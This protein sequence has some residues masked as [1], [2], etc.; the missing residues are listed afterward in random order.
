M[1][2]R[3]VSTTVVALALLVPLGCGNDGGSEGTAAAGGGV[4]VVTSFY[5]LQY[6][7][8]R[9][10]GDRV[11]V[12]NLTPPGAEPHDLE[13]TPQDLARLTDAD[14]VVYLAGFSPAV[15]DAVAA[16][17]GDRA[18]EVGQFADLNLTLTP[19]EEGAF[20][21]GD[22]GVDPHFW[23]DPTRLAD[24]ADQVAQRLGQDDPDGAQGF[25][26][27]AAA[28][29]RD[30]EAL[31]GELAAGLKDCENR[32]I[33]TSHNA[34]GYLADRFGMTQVGITGLTPDEEPTP[35]DL[36]AVTRFVKDH[37]VKTIYYETL[38]SP[39][40]AKT[41]AAETGA[42]SAVLDPIEGLSDASDGSD[43]L[44]VMR[45]NLASLQA[46]QPCG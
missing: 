46:G 22:K 39:A 6:V 5:P 10:G 15:D 3:S 13:L 37:D 31:D 11:A 32:S 19:S 2:P 29:R 14:L 43:Y 23:L 12:T 36:A 38:V 7:V 33:V 20:A 44:S 8:D 25:S 4:A 42:A 16:E 35:A 21:G 17:A 28:L 41:V 34:F 26:A 18:F 40:V 30:L 1:P 45:A 24:V 9:V 27:N